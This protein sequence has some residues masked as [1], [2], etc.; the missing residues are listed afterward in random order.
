MLSKIIKN[1][2]IEFF[3]HGDRQYLISMPRNM[4][5]MLDEELTGNYITSEEN[6]TSQ[7]KVETWIVP[8]VGEINFKIVDNEFSIKLIK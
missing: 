8:K 2:I 5:D 6:R 4:K 1:L 7:K 3:K